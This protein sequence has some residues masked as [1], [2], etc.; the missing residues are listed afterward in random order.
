MTSAGRTPTRS[1]RR[2]P[3][4]VGRDPAAGSPA[5]WRCPSCRREFRRRGQ[6]HECASALTLEEYFSTGPAFERPIFEA[7]RRHLEGLGPV[8]IE[9]VQ[10]GIF[11][12]RAATFAELRPQRRRVAL[13]M[14]LPRD[15]G[16]PRV[17]R[18]LPLSGARTACVVH[19]HGPQEVD[20]EVRGWL[21]ES[22]LSAPA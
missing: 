14:V 5:L 1:G 2:R 12:K 11:F 18:H 6:S 13:S 22:Y 4:E 15:I 8:R 17:A 9:A 19:L 20:E 3:G 10:V 21:S 16:H 7:V